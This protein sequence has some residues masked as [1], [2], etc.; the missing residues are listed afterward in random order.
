[1]KKRNF[2]VSLFPHETEIAKTLIFLAAK[3]NAGVTDVTIEHLR[4]LGEQFKDEGMEI[5]FEVIGN[6]QLCIDVKFN[7]EWQPSA[8]IEEIEIFKPVF[9]NDEAPAEIEN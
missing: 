4:T 1:M 5:N 6:T 7:E 8:V 3:H 2:R 9:K